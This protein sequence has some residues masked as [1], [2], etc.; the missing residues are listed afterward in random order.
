[1]AKV[2]NKDNKTSG[3]T[4][5]AGVLLIAGASFY[6]GV[7]Q[8]DQFK[9]FLGPQKPISKTE[10]IKF[11]TDSAKLITAC[12]PKPASCTID[13]A[14][15]VIKDNMATSSGT[16]SWDGDN[17]NISKTYFKRNK[18][19]PKNAIAC[20]DL[21]V[22]EKKFIPVS[23]PDAKSVT[24]VNEAQKNDRHDSTST[25]N[26]ENSNGAS[27][28]QSGTAHSEVN[29]G[30]NNSGTITQTTEVKQEIKNECVG[31]DNCNTIINNPAPT[32]APT[33]EPQPTVRPPKEEVTPNVPTPTPLIINYMINEVD[34]ALNKLAI[35][36][37]KRIV[38]KNSNIKN[39]R[40]A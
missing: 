28:S 13:E 18:D 32:A 21:A 3:I 40:K 15:K 6:S 4:K 34:K 25:S 5:A 38:F 30:G 24:T 14:T 22:K 29:V 33:S 2:D 16:F 20:E 26:Q 39:F 19:N 31:V 37:S 27:N 12:D 23:K 10:Q 7:T 8:S 11:A 1:M 17:W 36:Q 35:E 9:N